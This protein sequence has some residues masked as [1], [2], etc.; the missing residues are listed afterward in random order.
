MTGRAACCHDAGKLASSTESR[1]HAVLLLDCVAVR[2]RRSPTA[3]IDIVSSM[4][5]HYHGHVVADRAI[6]EEL[7]QGGIDGRNQGALSALRAA[8]MQPA[9]RV[10]V[11]VAGTHGAAGHAPRRGSPAATAVHTPRCCTA[12]RTPTAILTL[13][14][15]T[16]DSFGMSELTRVG[17]AGAHARTSGFGAGTRV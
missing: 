5:H 9:P 2:A 3:E 15:Q 17:A 1:A 16:H 4:D 10:H 14:A 6:G 13:T 12:D 8:C 7:P 11:E